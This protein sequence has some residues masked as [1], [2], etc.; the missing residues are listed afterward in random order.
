MKRKSEAHL[1]MV[2]SA[3]ALL[4]EAAE[5]LHMADEPLLAMSAR[6]TATKAQ[7]VSQKHHMLNAAEEM[8]HGQ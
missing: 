4:E 6:Q 7:A 8:T 5:L 3:K 1:A 2:K